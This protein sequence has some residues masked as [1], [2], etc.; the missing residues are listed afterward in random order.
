MKFKVS[1]TESTIREL[2]IE[3]DSP[4][5]AERKV[6]DGDADYDESCEVDATVVGVNSVEEIA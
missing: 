1:Y 4:E 5:E 2:E 6:I 3:A